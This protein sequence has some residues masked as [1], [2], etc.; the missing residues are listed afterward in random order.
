MRVRES[1]GILLKMSI[2]FRINSVIVQPELFAEPA[3]R[4]CT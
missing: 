4:I 3:E 1:T 2:F